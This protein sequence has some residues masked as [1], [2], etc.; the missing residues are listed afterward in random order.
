[1]SEIMDEDECIILISEEELKKF[2]NEAIKLSDLKY[3]GGKFYY[4][5]ILYTGKV[6]S[7]LEYF[8]LLIGNIKDGRLD[9]QWRKIEDMGDNE[10]NVYE[11]AHFKNNKRDGLYIR[12]DW[13]N[14]IEKIG[15]YINGKKEGIWK[16]YDS[17][18]NLEF[19]E[20][21]SKGRRIWFRDY[22]YNYKF[23]DNLKSC[24]KIGAFYKSEYFYKDGYLKKEYIL[25]EKE[26][27]GRIYYKSGQ[28][29]AEGNI[30]ESL[31]HNIKI[32]AW[33]Y[34]SEEGELQDIRIEYTYKEYLRK[35][36]LTG[37]HQYVNGIENGQGIIEET[38]L[39]EEMK[40][41]PKIIKEEIV[42]WIEGIRYVNCIPNPDT[43]EIKAK[44]IGK[45]GTFIEYHP[46]GKVAKEETYYD[47]Q[48]NGV[49]KYWH[50]DGEL[51]LVRRYSSG[52]II[53][54][55]WEHNKNKVSTILKNI[56]DLAVEW[57]EKENMKRLN[58]KK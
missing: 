40:E 34:Y 26:N 31:S 9:G 41:M 51:Y 14:T 39:K 58:S 35:D 44:E 42:E 46:N 15:Y 29:M 18:R 11:E 38:I 43:N 57:A 21:Y 55:A 56:W 53:E 49:A 16:E 45:T 50:D 20:F 1:M 5:N 37:Y 17:N 54:E 47:G 13:D 4:N 48:L 2:C 32:G 7:E 6:Y 36:G 8:R 24:Y 25:S 23:Y 10:I 12:R 28:L 19:E 52:S 33:N 3:R 27:V 22:K 30:L